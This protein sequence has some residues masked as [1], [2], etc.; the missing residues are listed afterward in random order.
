[1]TCSNETNQW[2]ARYTP[3]H[4][5]ISKGG[6]LELASVAIDGILLD[7]IVVTVLAVVEERK[8]RSRSSHAAASGG[9]GGC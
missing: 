7:E 5:S 1:M 3:S 2:L 8:R 6:V 9:G 4:F